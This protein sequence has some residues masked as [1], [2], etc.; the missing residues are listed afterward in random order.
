MWQRCPERDQYALGFA[1]SSIQPLGTCRAG[2]SPVGQGHWRVP[3]EGPSGQGPKPRARPT[4]PA[5]SGAAG[6][7]QGRPSPLP[8]ASPQGWGKARQGRGPTGGPGSAGPMA[9]AG[10]WGGLRAWG[11]AGCAPRAHP[12]RWLRPEENRFVPSRTSPRWKPEPSEWGR[13]RDPRQRHVH[14]AGQTSSAGA[15]IVILIFL[16]PAGNCNVFSLLRNFLCYL[17]LL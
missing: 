6:R 5:R 13:L 15:A 1:P 17:V 12:P 3:L 9:G 11:H 7:L 10:L 8:W 16:G 4:A 14:A 2:G